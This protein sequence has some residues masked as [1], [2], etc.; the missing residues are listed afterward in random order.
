[1]TD[2]PALQRIIEL[3]DADYRQYAG[4]PFAVCLLSEEGLFLNYNG[5]ARRLFDLPATPNLHD[6]LTD[7]YIQPG[8]RRDNLRRLYRLPRGEWLK[9]TTI[10]LKIGGEVCYVRDYS[11]AVWSS[12]G[13]RILALVCLM[14][15]MSRGDRYHRLFNELPVGIFSFRQ[16]AGLIHANPRFLEMHGYEHFDE[17]EGRDAAGF[18]HHPAELDRMSRQLLR[19]GCLNNRYQEHRRRDGSTFTA[20]V[21]A[22]AIRSDDGR[23]IGTEG[24][25]EDVTTEAIYFKL[26]NEVPVG[27]Y[28]VRINERG[29]HQLLH[30]NHRFAQH[31]GALPEELTGQDMRRFHPSPDDFDAFY[32]ELLDQESQGREPVAEMKSRDQAGNLRYYEVHARFLYDPDGRITGRVVAQRDITEFRETKQQLDELT[33]DIGK[34]LH[35]YSS[36]LIHAKQTMDAVIRSLAAPGELRSDNQLADEAALLLRIHQ[37]IGALDSAVEKILDKNE[38]IRHLEPPAVQRIGHLLRLFR[39]QDSRRLQVQQLAIIRDGGIQLRDL[40]DLAAEGNFPRELI[41]EARRHLREILRLCSLVTLDRGVDGILEM[42]TTVHN[43]RGYIL[44]RVKPPEPRQSVDLYDMLLGAARKMEEYAHHR[45]IEL[46]LQLKSVR[47]VYVEGYEDDLVRALLNLLHNAIKY[48]WTRRGPG[49]AF[50]AIEGRQDAEQVF[51]SIENWGVAITEQELRDGLIFQVG[52]RGLHSSD[53][54]RPGTGLGL[55]DARKVIEKHGGQLHITSK[56][57]LGNA[58][59]DYSNPFITTV[60]IQLPRKPAG[61]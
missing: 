7:F 16:A 4:L 47:D 41:K 24:T 53:R 40:L 61:A 60:T 20:S 54:R 49:K 35:S 6:N 5:E 23:W 12:D 28:S 8:D 44:T 32:Q 57:S 9:N 36:T 13:E 25:L 29:E 22:V 48:S 31:Y 11:R 1:M 38:T 43:L 3:S 21:S 45:D 10:D 52:Y 18:L 56:P 42:E 59:D 51:L 34:V 33:T 37:Q 15:P 27:L 14:I 50:V 55:Y 19:E 46:R 2:Q 39:G 58:P 30:C 26:V 17:V